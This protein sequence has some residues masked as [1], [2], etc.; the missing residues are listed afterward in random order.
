MINAFANE[1]DHYFH[2]T[3]IRSERQTCLDLRRQ[4]FYLWTFTIQQGLWE[5]ALDFMDEHDD[6]P[7][8]FELFLSDI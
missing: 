7:A 5:D 6:V 2:N 4:L 8:P 1:P 3:R